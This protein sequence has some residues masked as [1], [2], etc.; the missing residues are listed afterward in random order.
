[1]SK[2]RKACW[3]LG[4]SPSCGVGPRPGEPSDDLDA[5]QSWEGVVGP[6]PT[7]RLTALQL[8]PYLGQRLKGVS[9]PGAR[10]WAVVWLQP[11][12]VMDRPQE[13]GGPG[14]AG[15]E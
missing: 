5:L 14:Q 2:Q 11:A 10:S 12:G 6:T 13:L 4:P 8:N 7:R 15:R 1:M 9:E 3:S